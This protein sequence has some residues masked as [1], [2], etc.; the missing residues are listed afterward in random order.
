MTDDYYQKINYDGSGEE[1]LYVKTTSI[2]CTF[3][4]IPETVSIT[5][6]P[7]GATLGAG[8][9]IVASTA[10]LSDLRIN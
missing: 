1:S 4:V 2:I 3:A 8:G 6:G 7:V 9:S 10:D 5:V